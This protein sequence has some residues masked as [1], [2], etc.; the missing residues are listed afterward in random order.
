M[1]QKG[2]ETRV[3]SEKVGTTPE[4]QHRLVE[5]AANLLHRIGD[6]LARRRQHCTLDLFVSEAGE[7]GDDDEDQRGN[8]KGQLPAKRLLGKEGHGES[9]AAEFEAVA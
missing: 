8:E 1:P 2:D 3:T 6:P 4:V 9:I 5:H 7:Y